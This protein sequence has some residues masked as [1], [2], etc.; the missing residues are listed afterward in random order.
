MKS[1]SNYSSITTEQGKS[2]LDVLLLLEIHGCALIYCTVM[3]DHNCTGIRWQLHQQ[4]YRVEKY[5]QS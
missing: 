2:T 1:R 4:P 3:V 5:R